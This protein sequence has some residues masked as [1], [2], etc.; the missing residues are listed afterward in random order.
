MIFS[1]RNTSRISR[2]GGSASRFFA[3]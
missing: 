1:F 2:A 3:W